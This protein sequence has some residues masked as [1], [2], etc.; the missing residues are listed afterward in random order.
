MCDQL[1]LRSCKLSEADV[2]HV[3]TIV[4]RTKLEELDLS[5][6]TLTGCV[7]S[8]MDSRPSSLNR[9]LLEYCKLS[10][11]DVYCLRFGFVVDDQSETSFFTVYEGGSFSGEKC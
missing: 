4:R 2:K 8:L 3:A 5:E 7:A 10:E 9:I 6:N 1:K 11:D